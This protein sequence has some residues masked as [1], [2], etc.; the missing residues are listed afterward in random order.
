MEKY[1][2]DC[3]S[4]KGENE[5]CP[6]CGAKGGGILVPHQLKQGTVLSRRYL[7]GKAIGQGGFGITYIGRDLR[8]DMKIA[9]KEYYPSGYANRNV[10][11]SPDI[12]ISNKRQE[13]FIE[14]GKRKFLNEARV[15]AQFNDEPGIVDVRDF[16]E[17]NSTAYIIMEYLEGQ[18]IRS[19]LKQELFPA[20]EILELVKP[21]M[22]ALEKIHAKG[23]VH[24]DI[25]PD[26]L[27]LVN[28]KQL[29]LMDFG[30]ARLVDFSDQK[31]VS[32]VLKA[33]YAPEEQYRPKGVQG[34]W[35]DIYALCATIYKCVTGITPDDALQRGYQDEL[36][37]PSELGIEMTAYQ[38]G[39]LRK[40]MSVKQE[41]RYQTVE[42]LRAA[43]YKKGQAGAVQS[44]EITANEPE[45]DRTV[46]FAHGFGAGNAESGDTQ[47]EKE[48]LEEEKNSDLQEGEEAERKENS[49]SQE[50][51][52]IEGEKDN[53]IQEEAGREKNGNIQKQD[54][55]GKEENSNPQEEKTKKEKNGIQREKDAN[56]ERVVEGKDGTAAEG[57]QKGKA[58]DGKDT[59]KK[60]GKIKKRL[61][62]IGSILL[63]AVVCVGA[64]CIGRSGEREAIKEEAKKEQEG[65]ATG[66]T[67]KAAYDPDTMYHITLTADEAM[68]VKEFNEAIE[69]LKG[70]MDVFAGTGGYQMEVDDDKVQLYIRKTRFA[71]K[72]IKYTL[73]CYLTRAINLS[74]CGV[75]EDGALV[76]EESMP[77]TRA[78]IEKVEI[79]EG[80]IEGMDGQKY[81]IEEDSYRYVEIVLD[82]EFLEKLSGEM[83]RWQ[84]EAVLVQDAGSSEACY[85]P[86]RWTEDGKALEV[87]ITDFDGKFIDV[88]AYNW[89]NPPLSDSFTFSIDV[90]NIAEWEEA[91]GEDKGRYQRGAEELR[92]QTVT[93]L[94]RSYEEEISEGE[95]LDT[96]NAFR[97]R[98][99]LLEQPYAIGRYVEDGKTMVAVKTELEHMGLPVMQLIGERRSIIQLQG[100]LS[101]RDLSSASI[102][103]EESGNGTYQV[104]VEADSSELEEVKQ[105]SELL[106]KKGGGNLSVSV[107]HLPY[108]QEFVDKAITDG[109]LVFSELVF[110]EDKKITDENVWMAQLLKE[111]LSGSKMPYDFEVERMVF[112][113]DAKGEAADGSQFGCTTSLEAESMEEK[114]KKIDESIEVSFSADNSISVFLHLPVDGTLPEKA[115]ELVRQIYKESGFVDSV[116]SGIGF[117]LADEDNAA[118]ERARIFFTKQYNG[119][120]DSEKEIEDGEIYVHGIFTGGRMEQWKDDFKERVSKSKFIKKYTGEYTSW[121]YDAWIY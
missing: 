39:V 117:Y 55:A 19:Y 61:F 40:G 62:S 74:L 24:R 63:L 110:S 84:N 13:A 100:S 97:K 96:I 52:K 76:G 29:K 7:V 14:D 93:I 94:Y 46:Y 5:V 105:I 27:M 79:K 77:L 23:I 6:S 30:A 11:V 102:S 59:D 3:M 44:V 68:S 43:F 118:R 28:Q 95:W 86:I 35:T 34:P 92:G 72:E 70:R 42:E 120:S 15:L 88:A 115:L 81:G 82:D 9:I 71:D 16:F 109:K 41:D 36:K 56:G 119:Y 32:V 4:P 48:A 58:S 66:S 107:N 49:N 106:E 98:L 10:S 65:S 85:C 73:R 101:N 51:K 37:W 1:C 12:T 103:I 17:E 57:T 54:R 112:N 116:Y 31:S 50:E 80:T 91:K 20:K 113:P 89:S 99:D 38:E 64:F 45:D 8:L 111:T 104:M 60:D 26:N 22:E 67:E 53:G 25:S 121:Y 47:E 78:N 18:D 108:V 33:G 114:V 2:M 90:E 21:V 69:I 87:L 75:T 83:G